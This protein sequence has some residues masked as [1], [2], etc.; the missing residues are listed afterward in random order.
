MTAAE[1]VRVKRGSKYGGAHIKAGRWKD[2]GSC[3]PLFLQV[4]LPI[5]LRDV[6]THHRQLIRSR[7]AIVLLLMVPVNLRV[8]TRGAMKML[9]FSFTI[10]SF[11]EMMT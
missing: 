3:R 8:H 1:D 7:R 2:F 11:E 6:A 10:R 5:T 4:D 9:D